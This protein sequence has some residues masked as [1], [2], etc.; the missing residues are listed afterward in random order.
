MDFA[1]VVSDQ[2][3]YFEGGRAVEAGTAN[4]V[5]NNPKHAETRAFMDSF[6]GGR[7]NARA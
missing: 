6:H 2:V 5:F 3:I 7:S 1:H 4:D